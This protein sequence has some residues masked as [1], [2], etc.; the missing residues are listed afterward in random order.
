MAPKFKLDGPK[1]VVPP[2]ASNPSPTPSPA[3]NSITTPTKPR[4]IQELSSGDEAPISTIPSRKRRMSNSQQPATPRKVQIGPGQIPVRAAPTRPEGVQFT[5]PEIQHTIDQVT[6]SRIPGAVDPRVLNRMIAKAIGIWNEPCEE[7]L[8]ATANLLKEQ[9][10]ERIDQVFASYKQTG[11][12]TR[13]QEIL[14]AFREGLVNEQREILL[15]LHRLEKTQIWMS[16]AADQKRDRDQAMH[17]L[18]RERRQIRL[19]TL[20]SERYPHLFEDPSEKVREIQKKMEELQPELAKTADKFNKE[21]SVAAE[22]QG[23]ITT[24]HKRFIDNVAMSV[25]GNLFVKMGDGI[26]KVLHDKLGVHG[27]DAEEKC[28]ALLAEDSSRERR[29]MA[30]KVQKEKLSQAQGQLLRYKES[31]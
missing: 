5:L 13:V 1:D 3:K 4:V 21:L 17:V 15:G 14:E 30:L 19:C 25:L 22:V 16:D 27:P 12:Y 11:I 28:R 29:R 8:T 26:L 31:S 23:Y 18:M 20:A 10:A 2:S 6:M 9:L 7:F 24:A